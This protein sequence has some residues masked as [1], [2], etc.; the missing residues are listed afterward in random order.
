MIST[1]RI[2]V[3]FLTKNNQKQFTT[4]SSLTL[5]LWKWN[6]NLLN[7]GIELEDYTKLGIFHIYI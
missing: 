2:S 7:S 5:P 1:G 3:G 6:Q 4:I